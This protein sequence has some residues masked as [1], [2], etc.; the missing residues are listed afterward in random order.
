MPVRKVQPVGKYQA[1]KSSQQGNAS[2]KSSTSREVSGRQVQLAEK[3]STK[4]AVSRG[5]VSK[6]IPAS[7]EMPVRKVQ[8]VEKYQEDK[9]SQ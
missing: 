9:S 8:P 1:D 2:K 5:N 6:K 3:P 4:I 7:R